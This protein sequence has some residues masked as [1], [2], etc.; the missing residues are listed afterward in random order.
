MKKLFIIFIFLFSFA[1]AQK[2]VNTNPT[3]IYQSGNFKVTDFDLHYNISGALQTVS[4]SFYYW[5]TEKK[6]LSTFLGISTSILFGMIK[7]FA[8]D[9]QAS[10]S[11]IEADIKGSITY[12][13]FTFGSITDIER[14]QQIDTLKFQ[15]LN[16]K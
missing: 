6:T 15:N 8:I 9:K 10:S 5:K 3:V 13:F 2:I 4:T 16:K 12:G 7:E 1:K 11:D 14:K